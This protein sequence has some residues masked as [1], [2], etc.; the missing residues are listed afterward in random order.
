MTNIESVC[1]K[2]NFIL[3]Y[4]KN[5]IVRMKTIFLENINCYDGVEKIIDNIYI[6]VLQNAYFFKTTI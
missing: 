5:E 4:D 3:N 2:N 1:L 6:E